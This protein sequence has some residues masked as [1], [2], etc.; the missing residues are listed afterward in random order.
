MKNP[1]VLVH[2]FKD[3]GKKMARLAAYLRAHGWETHTPT[4]APSWG[5]VGIDALARQLA[6]FIDRTL[7]VAQKFDL[8]GF[9]MGG[10]ATRYYLQKLGGHARVEHYISLAAPHHGTAMAYLWPLPGAR[11][12][13]F[14]SEFLREL[15]AGDEI[16]NQ[17]K[18]TTIWT[19]LDLMIVPATSSR[20][21]RIQSVTARAPVDGGF[22][23]GLT[24]H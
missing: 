11:Q 13:R 5:Q 10:L 18:V 19:P 21:P 17:L 7:P 3:S 20:L 12:M 24:T 15:A 1:V 16:L 22:Q 14:G 6:A 4:L 23:T 2:G 9:S 8:I